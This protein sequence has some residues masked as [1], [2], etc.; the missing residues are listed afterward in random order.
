M[1]DTTNLLKINTG[2]QQNRY[3]FAFKANFQ[4]NFLKGKKAG[5]KKLFQKKLFN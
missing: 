4:D 5:S 1:K 3:P 2:T